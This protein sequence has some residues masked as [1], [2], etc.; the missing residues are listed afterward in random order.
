MGA[1]SFTTSAGS[2]RRPRVSSSAS[3]QPGTNR[4]T[5]SARPLEFVCSRGLALAVMRFVPG[6]SLA[7]ELTRG[8]RFEPAEVVKLLAPIADALAHAHRGGVIHRD[9]KPANIL[10]HAD[11]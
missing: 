1:S 3:E 11:D 5:A 4:I 9:V 6:C 7:D 10:L 8:R 2:K